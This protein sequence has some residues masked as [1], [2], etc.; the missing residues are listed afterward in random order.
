LAG[1]L[2]LTICLFVFHP[3]HIGDSVTMFNR[4]RRTGLIT[5]ALAT[6]VVL[7]LGIYHLT[8]EGLRSGIIELSMASLL[9]IS[10]YLISRRQ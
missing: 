1:L 2:L 7:F 4:Y 3:Q 10:G 5:I 6:C 8:H 9:V